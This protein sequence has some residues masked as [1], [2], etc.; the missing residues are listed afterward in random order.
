[1][2]NKRPSPI[3]RRRFLRDSCLTAGATAGLPLLSGCPEELPPGMLAELPLS[4]P[5]SVQLVEPGRIRF[6]FETREDRALPVRFE[7][8]SW[9][10]D[11]IPTTDP[12]ELTY[13]WG[14]L[15]V[16]GLLP[17]EAGLHVVQEVVFDF[18]EP[19]QRVS[20][21]ID[22]GEERALTGSF[23]TPPPPGTAFRFGW[24]ADTMRPNT[25]DSVG[26]LVPEAP[27]LVLHG[28][29][30]QYQSNPFDT[31]NSQLATFAPITSTAPF[32]LVVGNHEFE[33]QSEITVMWD[34]LF[35]G[36]GGAPIQQ[37]YHAFTWGSV[38]FIGMD[39]ETS[40]WINADDPQLEWLRL[41]LQA[42][43]DD[44]ALVHAVVFF[45]RPLFT[46]S[47]YWSGSTGTRDLLH[48]LFRDHGVPLVLCGHVHAYE[49]WQV[50]G[51]HYVVD[52]GGGALTYDPREKLEEVEAARPGESELQLAAFRTHGV[53][54]VDV[55]ADGALSVRR[56]HAD[57]GIVEDEFEVAV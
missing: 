44:P 35:G 42:V 18:P 46:L 20:W 28:G 39:S 30:F 57:E 11:A 49:H 2:S 23:G 13:A 25:D 29:D 51:V 22:L 45:H 5:P 26:R 48:P 27:D 9:Q 43:D 32:H 52:G 21:T 3:T 34:R 47:K 38:R 36:Q 4:K 15:D 10:L 17:D 16:A 37:R 53:T 31:W 6:R 56:I 33:G 40:G 8:G 19:G 41:E 12:R 1:M 7:Q 14:L 24:I 50:E 54:V 55:A